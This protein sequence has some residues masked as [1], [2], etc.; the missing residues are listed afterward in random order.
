MSISKS[1][2]AH[3]PDIIHL[4]LSFIKQTKLG[5]R[6][7]PAY[8]VG[9]APNVK[10]GLLL[11]NIHSKR[12]VIRRTFTVL[13]P[14]RYEFGV[15]KDH[16]N[17]VNEVGEDLLYGPVYHKVVYTPSKEFQ[18]ILSTSDIEEDRLGIEGVPSDRNQLTTSYTQAKL[19]DVDQ[20]ARKYFDK[21]GLCYTDTSS[22][23][24]GEGNYR[25]DDIVLRNKYK[26]G[27]NS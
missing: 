15:L 14:C 6:N 3:H 19:S 11:Y 1:G 24:G 13:G 8:A 25:T 18:D 17:G 4:R 23:E 27:K 16:G 12:V 26:Q 9:L 22:L 20:R 10:G 7:F 21:I 5:G 2:E